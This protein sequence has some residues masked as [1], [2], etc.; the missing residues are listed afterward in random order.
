MNNSNMKKDVD[1]SYNNLVEL[2]N[3]SDFNNLLIS[4]K[5]FCIDF[6]ENINGYN[7]LALAYKNTGNTEKALDLYNRLIKIKHNQPSIFTNAGNL[8][9]SLGNIDKAIQ[10]HNT[11]IKMDPNSVSSYNGLG[12]AYFNSGKIKEAIKCYKKVLKIDQSQKYVNVNIGN[13][14]RSLQKYEEAASFYGKHK[15]KISMAQ[16]LECYYRVGMLKEFD[17]AF[18]KYNSIF[19]YTPLAATLSSH[20]SIVYSRRDEYGFCNNPFNFISKTNI[21]DDGYN[22]SIIK[23]FINNFNQLNIIK[24]EQSLLKNG[25]QSSGNIFLQKNKAIDNIKKIIEKKI[26]EYRENFSSTNAGIVSHWPKN[27]TLY[28]WLI[29]LKNQGSLLPHAHKEGWLSGSLYLSIPE[30]TSNS[31]DGDLRFSYDGGDYPKAIKN[32]LKKLLV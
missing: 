19:G 21:F 29:L 2:Y 6:P 5:E 20:A 8:F 32:F 26:E 31:N 15:T 10:C 4:A 3:K 25:F 7:I 30:K 28:G 17:Y 23:N 18:K 22:E 16:Q 27:Y 24:K 14:L 9:H 13:C 12:L 11:A 1:T